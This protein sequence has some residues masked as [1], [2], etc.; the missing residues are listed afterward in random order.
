MSWDL[1]EPTG[2]F[3]EPGNPKSRADALQERLKAMKQ[4]LNA[5]DESKPFETYGKRSGPV[6]R[7]L[8]GN[9]GNVKKA[10]EGA[11]DKMW[12]ISNDFNKGR[13][14]LR[15]ELFD[16]QREVERLRGTGKELEKK[17]GPTDPKSMLLNFVDL[18]GI[19]RML[20]KGRNR[21]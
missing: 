10:L 1:E 16:Q 19:Q 11:R 6:P 12:K 13:A 17:L 4:K 20:D 7:G 21:Q 5:P 8:K 9:I 3:S 18:K 15:E 14:E 2:G